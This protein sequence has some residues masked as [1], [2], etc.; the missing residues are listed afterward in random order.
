MRRDETTG[1]GVFPQASA[2]QSA[3]CAA[4]VIPLS[5]PFATIFSCV[6]TP[7]KNAV[8]NPS[9]VFLLGRKQDGDGD[10]RSDF[11]PR[12]GYRVNRVSSQVCLGLHDEHRQRRLKG[13]S[14]ITYRFRPAPGRTGQ[15]NGTAYKA[16]AGLTSW[17]IAHINPQSSLAMAVTTTVGCFPLALRLR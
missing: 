2:P 1:A 17:P 11:H 7:H 8:S 9:V 5:C 6:S 14:R 16:V 13:D 12:V 15:R 4:R 3:A 10:G